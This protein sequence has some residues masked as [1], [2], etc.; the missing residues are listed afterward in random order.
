MLWKLKLNRIYLFLFGYFD[1]FG[2]FRLVLNEGSDLLWIYYMGWIGNSLFCLFIWGL[3]N[4]EFRILLMMGLTK[5]ENIIISI[6][7]YK[8]PKKFK[9]FLY[10]Y[11]NIRKNKKYEVKPKNIKRIIYLH[12]SW[13]NHKSIYHYYYLDCISKATSKRTKRNLSWI[14]KDCV[15]R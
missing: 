1:D 6:I 11:Q 12:I 2:K 4:F 15:Q 3:L 8:K 9:Y 13:T 14:T 5:K 7:L 10:Y